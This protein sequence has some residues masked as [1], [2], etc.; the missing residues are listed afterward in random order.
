MGATREPGRTCSCGVQ[1]QQ[2]QRLPAQAHCSRCAG[3]G[4]AAAGQHLGRHGRGHEES[5]AASGLRRLRRPAGCFNREFSAEWFR[6]GTFWRYYSDGRFQLG[7]FQRGIGLE[8]AGLPQ[9]SV[10]PLAIQMGAMQYDAMR[11]DVRVPRPPCHVLTGTALTRCSTHRALDERAQRITIRCDAIRCDLLRRY[12]GLVI[13]Y[14]ISYDI[15]HSGH[16]P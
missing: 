12:P 7:V 3:S 8:G 16:Y 6:P 13:S 1:Q 5:R 2:I 9:T 4:G 15:E 10:A 14:D 11:H